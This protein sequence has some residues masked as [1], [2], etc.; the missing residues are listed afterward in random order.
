MRP[1][2]ADRPTPTDPTARHLRLPG[3]RNLRDVGGYPTLDGRR[4]R[5]G[6]LLRTDALDLLPRSSRDA[7]LARGLRCVIDLRWPDE[8]ASWPSVFAGDARIRYESIP[9]LADDPTPHLGLVGMYRHIL[10][11]RGE[12][13]AGIVRTLVEPDGLPAVVGCAAGKDRTGV[14]IALLL[15]IARVPAEVIVA[16]Y[17]LTFDAFADPV[18]GDASLS[19]WRSTPLALECPPAHMEAMLAHLETRHGGVGPL[20]QRHGIDASTLARVRERLTEPTGA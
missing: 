5:W 10:D 14:T 20:L 13:L 16:D 3:T 8:L 11:E 19:D 4:T 9:L 7:L 2:L 17:A 6:V 15:A 18:H 12:Q 1:T